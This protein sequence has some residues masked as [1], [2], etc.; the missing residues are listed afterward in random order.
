MLIRNFKLLSLLLCSSAMALATTPVV[1]VSSPANG[2]SVGTPVN[3]AASASSPG[4]S[5]GISAMRIYTASGVNAFTI[6]T[7]KLSTNINLPIGSYNTV[8]QAWDNCGG[9]GK[10]TVSIKVSKVNLAPPKFLYGTEFKAGRIAEYVVNPLNGSIKPTT[11]GS[12]FAHFG[13]VDI[14][15]DHWGNHLYVANDGSHDLDAYFINRSSG[16]LT[17]VPGSPFALTGRGLRV[18]VQPSGHFVYATSNNSSS[19]G[20]ISA[21]AVKSNGSLAPVPGSPFAEA[22]GTEGALAV[23]PNGKYLYAAVSLPGSVGAVAVYE[24]NQTNGALTQVQGSPFP[25]PTYAGCSSFCR[26]QPSD[27]QVDVTG[28]FLYAAQAA[29][30]AIAAFRIEPTT[31]TL[32]DLPGSPYPDGSFNTDSTPKDPTRLSINPN[33]KFIYTADDEGESISVWAVNKS[34]GVPTFRASLQPCTDPNVPGVLVPLTVPVDPSGSFVYTEGHQTNGCNIP[35]ESKGV[36][37]GFSIDQ[38]SGFLFSVPGNPFV[39]QNL[40]TTTISRESVVVTR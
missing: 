15:S 28:T 3:Y 36:M 29:Q 37:A 40:D 27:L 17:Q 33:G 22:S 26:P 1:T 13:P 38:G 12:I 18:V 7:N 16:N 14:A 21:F 6:H 24:I 19:V 9:V 34:T 23:H 2:A 10:T 35:P 30:D 32:T 11:Q 31:G 4:C 8:V 39:N 5:K 20:E 25:V